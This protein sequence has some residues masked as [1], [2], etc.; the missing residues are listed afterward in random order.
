MSNLIN[1]LPFKS[2]LNL[3]E[4]DAKISNRQKLKESQ[5]ATS[6]RHCRLCCQ[7]QRS[8]M[9]RCSSKKMLE[10]FCVIGN[11]A[12]TTRI[13]IDYSTEDFN[14]EGTIEPK[15]M[16]RLQKGL[17][18]TF[19]IQNGLSFY[20]FLSFINSYQFFHELSPACKTFF[21][22]LIHVF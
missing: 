15:K 10:S 20:F 12:V 22:F 4:P 19:I 17:K 6:V 16:P 18:T 8:Y 14:F 7:I 1:K 2:N 3:L 9:F 5:I 11:L 21:P 13:A